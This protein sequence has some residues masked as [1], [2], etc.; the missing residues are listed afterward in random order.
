MIGSWGRNDQERNE[1]FNFKVDGGFELLDYTCYNSPPGDKVAYD[2]L[3]PCYTFSG[4]YTLSGDQLSL[5]YQS[6]SAKQDQ[7]SVSLPRTDQVA[8]ISIKNKTLSLMRTDEPA[9][10]YLSRN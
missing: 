8:R 2:A 6:V 10:S 3:V 5:S 7:E 9:R 4:T 1:V